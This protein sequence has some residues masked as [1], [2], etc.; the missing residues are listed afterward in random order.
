MQVSDGEQLT[1]QDITDRGLAAARLAG[2]VKT[3]TIDRKAVEAYLFRGAQKQLDKI[4][5]EAAEIGDKLGGSLNE[6][7]LSDYE[8]KIAA[9]ITMLIMLTTVRGVDARAKGLLAR[10]EGL[11]RKIAEIR[12]AQGAARACRW[13]TERCT[14]SSRAKKAT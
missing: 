10:F 11:Q 7:Q 13:E 12:A 14:K 6:S 5:Q 4:G 9:S 3:L 2:A 8:V 1:A